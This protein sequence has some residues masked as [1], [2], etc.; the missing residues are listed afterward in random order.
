MCNHK[1]RKIDM[2][3]LFKTLSTAALGVAIVTL[4]ACSQDELNSPNEA[5]QPDQHTYG[6]VLNGARPSFD[7]TR[8]SNSAWADNSKIYLRLKNGT[9]M[10]N[11]TATYDDYNQAWTVNMNG[12]PAKGSNSCEARYFD[13]V[14]QTNTGFAFTDSTIVYEDLAGQYSFDGSKVVI[15]AGLAPIVARVRFVGTGGNCEAVSGIRRY[16]GYSVALNRY[17]TTDDA[18]QLSGSSASPYYYGVFNDENNRGLLFS[19]D[20]QAFYNYYSSEV[21]KRGTSG[22]I[23][24]PTAANL[25]GWKDVNPFSNLQY[26][27]SISLERQEIITKCLDDMVKVTSKEFNFQND[28]KYPTIV[29]PFYIMKTEVTQKLYRAVMGHDF[30]G[31]NDVYG[32]S[33]GDNMPIYCWVGNRLECTGETFHNNDYVTGDITLQSPTYAT[34][35]LAGNLARFVD[36]LQHITGLNFDYPTEAEWEYAAWGGQNGPTY[37]N[38]AGSGYVNAVSSE[39]TQDFG[40]CDVKLKKSNELGLYDMTGNVS[41]VC[42]YLGNLTD[43]AVHFNYNPQGWADDENGS[44]WIT[45]GGNNYD[46][47]YG[48]SS[49]SYVSSRIRNSD[50]PRMQYYGLRLV[51]RY[52]MPRK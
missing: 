8:A 30:V 46:I 29:S 13:N 1:N 25:R 52:N 38:Y 17:T 43:L 21:M 50:V 41:E 7:D 26:P 33:I 23:T 35:Y 47:A 37:S 14:N 48:G 9:S 45:R 15:T 11:A 18:I 28:S 34:S 42:Y 3:T 20:Q 36:K 5:Q 51:L 12:T 44:Y 27:D 32:S 2:K 6:M 16:T 4:A 49:C 19:N 39:K 24:L 31:Y 40:V 10:I 22:Y